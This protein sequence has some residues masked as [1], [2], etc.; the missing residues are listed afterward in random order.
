M[1]REQHN[2]NEKKDLEQKA[3]QLDRACQKLDSDLHKK[4][5]DAKTLQKD[6]QEICRIGQECENCCK[7]MH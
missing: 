3:K 5:I 7:K 4:S 2:P 1:P 6:C